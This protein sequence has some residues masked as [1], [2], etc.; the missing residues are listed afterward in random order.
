[1][2]VIRKIYRNN[3]YSPSDFTLQLKNLP[4]MT[5]MSAVKKIKK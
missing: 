2:R 5:E 3:Y 4:D 1:M